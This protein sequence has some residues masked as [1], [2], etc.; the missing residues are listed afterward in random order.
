MKDELETNLAGEETA[1]LNETNTPAETPEV[2]AE[3]AAV[4]SDNAEESAA[5]K[6]TK[7]EILNNKR[8]NPEP[9]TGFGRCSD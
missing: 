8:R 6:I 5:G 1:K 9:T 2:T 3:A 7:E 4:E